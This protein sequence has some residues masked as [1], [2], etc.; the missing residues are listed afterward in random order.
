MKARIRPARI[1]DLDFVTQ[2][3]LE[4]YKNYSQFGKSV[5]GKVFFRNH[6]LLIKKCLET[7]PCYVAADIQDD[8]FLLGFICLESIEGKDIDVLHF[9][10][11]RR[12]LRR[13]G[14][15]SAL[16]NQVKRFDDLE[17]SHQGDIK[18]LFNLW[19]TKLY[20]PYHFFI[21]AE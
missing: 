14:I 10:F 21:G 4:Y 1:D 20:N 5:P 9:M 11:T 3:W 18:S 2:S 19:K 17:F 7:A 8:S 16:I 13:S 12:D 15:G 6:R